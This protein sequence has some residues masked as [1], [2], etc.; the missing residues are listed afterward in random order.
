MYIP[1]GI[2]EYIYSTAERYLVLAPELCRSIPLLYMC[3]LIHEEEYIIL[4][5]QFTFFY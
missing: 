2:E 1:T 5:V 4:F 3:I